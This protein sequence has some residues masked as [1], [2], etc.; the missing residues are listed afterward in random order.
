MSL[1]DFLGKRAFAALLR[2]L[3]GRISNGRLTVTLP[4]GSVRV[5]EGSEEGPVAELTIH[6]YRFMR[7]V[8][9]LGSL[10]FAEAYLE[11]DCSTP[12]MRAVLDFTVANARWFTSDS[13]S[14]RGVANFLARVRHRRRDNTRKGA[15]RNIACHYDLGND[16]YAL[17]LDPSMTYSSAIFAE[18]VTDLEAAQQEKYRRLAEMMDLAPGKRVVEIGCGWGGFAAFA[19]REYGAQVTGL[20]I[21]AQQLAYGRNRIKEAELQDK[22]D[23]MFC[24]YREHQGRDYDALVSIEMFEAVGERHWRTY[25][26]QIS[27]FLRPGGKAALQ[28]ITI[29]EAHFAS[30]RASP[31]FIQKYIFPGGMLPTPSHLRDLSAGVGLTI[32]VMNAYRQDYARTLDSW[33]ANFRAAWDRIQPLGFDDRFKRLWEYYLHYCASGFMAGTID[34]KQIGLVKG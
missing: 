7:R 9:R 20:T 29:D 5:I 34:V 26:D 3:D 31:D 14:S 18:G 30:Y 13:F 4:D 2:R 22:V 25:F 27:A 28:I 21:S 16:F 8:L 15:K 11:E 32:K 24:D 10:G 19:A 6:S 12:D 17:W 33:L 1:A 23:L